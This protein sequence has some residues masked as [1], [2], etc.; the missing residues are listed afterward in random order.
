MHTTPRIYIACLASYNNG[1]LHGAW[2][3]AEDVD[4]IEKGI[5]AVLSS[6]PTEGAEEY[7]IHDHEGFGPLDIREYEDIETV[8]QAGAFITKHG[9]VGAAW[10]S[11]QGYGEP[12]DDIEDNFN[13]Q[14]QGAHKDIADFAE[15][16]LEDTGALSEIPESLRYYFDFEKYAH[17]LECGGYY[18]TLD[19]D[20]ECH[21][22]RS[23]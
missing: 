2:V 9:A 21:V 22:F 20:G 13:D 16:L 10:L 15:Q 4:V 12:R 14:Y 23:T 3:D 17:Y 5:A 8:A 19:V 7:A 1:L 11:N 6:S 18:Y